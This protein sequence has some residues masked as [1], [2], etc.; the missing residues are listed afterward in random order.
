[1]ADGYSNPLEAQ[2]VDDGGFD[3]GDVGQ[4]HSDSMFGGDILAGGEKQASKKPNLSNKSS[5]SQGAQGA[6]ERA[7][8]GNQYGDKV[9]EGTV[10]GAMRMGAAGAAVGALKFVNKVTGRTDKTVKPGGLRGVLNK[11]IPVL[12]IVGVMTG[13]LGASV[14]GQMSLG[15]AL[16]EQVMRRFDSMSVENQ[17]VGKN[18]LKAQLNPKTRRVQNGGEA[19]NYLR[20]HGK[21]Y[22]A[23]TGDTGEKYFKMSDYQESKLNQKGIELVDMNDGTGRKY[24]KFTEKDNQGRVLSVTN[25]V[26]DADQIS[27][28]P[29]SIDFESA[30]AA[31]GN[32]TFQKA[33]YEGAKTFRSAVGDWFKA[34]TG[35]LLEALG[36]SRNR[37]SE[38]DGSQDDAT[39]KQQVLDTIESSVDD[40]GIDGKIDTASY[41]LEDVDNDPDNP[42]A[43]SHHE[44]TDKA[45]STV[46]S[47][48]FSAPS[49]EDATPATTQAVEKT[50]KS[51]LDAVSETSGRTIGER[52]CNMAL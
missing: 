9:K 43:G 8:S 7:A 25:V 32:S 6:R 42:D 3:A 35:K 16:A 40:Q 45:S 4:N 19:H 22:Q 5:D 30:M 15:V 46:Q 41:D 37:F 51:K 31:D 39:R 26:A 11:A 27:S 13:F 36:V 2:N 49:G 52:R 14:G 28:V 50:V 12:I 34:K 1:M 20:Q 21:I 10:G 17:L 24:M 47:G 18:Y 38:F 48:S 23:F 33:Y 44:V 29:G